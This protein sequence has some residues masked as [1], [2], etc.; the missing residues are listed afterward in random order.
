MSAHKSGA[1]IFFHV[2][3]LRGMASPSIGEGE[4]GQQSLSAQ[5]LIFSE[6]RNAA[7]LFL[8]LKIS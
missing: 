7:L 4:H 5:T 3:L 8:L 1:I 6:G 2:L